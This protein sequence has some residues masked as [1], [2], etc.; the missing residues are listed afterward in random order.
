MRLLYS[1][2]VHAGIKCTVSANMSYLPILRI[3]CL[4]FGILFSLFQQVR[5]YQQ[6]RLPR[7]GQDYEEQLR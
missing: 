5:K 6:V 3:Y 2:V 1:E 7:R 4:P